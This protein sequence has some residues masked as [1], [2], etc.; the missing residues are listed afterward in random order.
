[1]VLE[2]SAY[3]M[4]ILGTYMKGHA[5][6][7]YNSGEIGHSSIN[8]F[9]SATAG[10]QEPYAVSAFFGN[11]AKL[12]RPNDNREVTNMGYSGYLIS[13][14][15]KHI[16]DNVYIKDDWIE[17][18]WKI[19]GKFIYPDMKMDWSFRAGIKQNNNPDIVDVVYFSVHRSN[20]D[21]H[22]PF[23]TW[24]SNSDLDL[25]LFF[26][27]ANGKLVRQEFIVGKKYP[28]A[29][30]QYTPTLDLGLIWASP[31]EYA[32]A[33]RTQPVKNWTLVFRPSVDF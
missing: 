33:L 7:L 30:R 19:K 6:G 2:A 20:L 4:P 31:D 27:Q 3:P 1:M 25:K 29:G 12:V 8:V 13:A 24:L 17:L 32:G 10:F 23:M 14:G 22:A 11:V 18:E 26:S 28:M 9:Q 15:N 5:P 16:K 21:I